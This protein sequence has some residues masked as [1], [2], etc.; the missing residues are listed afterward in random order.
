MEVTCTNC[1]HTTQLDLNF[2]VKIY[3]C[4]NCV[5]VYQERDGLRFK[6]QL[7]PFTFS[8]QLQVGQVGVFNNTDYTIMGIL[9]KENEGF[10]WTEYILQ[11]KENFLYLSEADGHWI[12]LEEIEFASKVGNHPLTVDYE[13][14]T[15]DRYDFFYP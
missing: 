13:E 10:E 3:A 9:V 5:Y 11:G 15:F 7:R 2:D 8:D 4:T 14:L 6:D 12:I 1:N